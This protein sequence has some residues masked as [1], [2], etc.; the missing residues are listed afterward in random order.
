[1]LRERAASI[2][3]DWRQRLKA[4][5]GNYLKGLAPETEQNAEMVA[6]L[7]GIALALESGS[8]AFATDPGHPLAAALRSASQVRVA[9]GFT[10]EESL[11]FVQ[12]CKSAWIDALHSHDALNDQRLA[13]TLRIEQLMDRCVLIL[14]ASFV[15]AREDVIRRQSESLR[16]VST[17]VITLWDSILLMPLVGVV[18]SVRAQH[19]SERLL[20]AIGQNE[21]EVTLIDVT[22]VPVMDTSVARHILKTVAAAEMLGTRVVLTG[23]SPST[24]Q[25][26]VKLGIDMSGV[27]TRGSLK[28]GMSLALTLTR[29]RIV[30][31]DGG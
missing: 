15:S 12:T 8:E 23:I 14:A 16:E 9:R 30:D 22:G 17:P 13:A 28:A 6:L 26:M 2:Q 24:A 19:I 5:G 25:T 27:P 10:P 31:A 20:E 3:G 18:D 1:M 29:R 11:L 21:A 7:A 4:A